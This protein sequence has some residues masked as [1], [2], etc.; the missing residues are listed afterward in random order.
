MLP[1]HLYIYKKLINKSNTKSLHLLQI[2]LM[3]QFLSPSFFTEV[4]SKCDRW[5]ILL[6]G[7]FLSQWN[8]KK[9]HNGRNYKCIHTVNLIC[10]FWWFQRNITCSQSFHTKMAYLNECYLSVAFHGLV[11]IVSVI[12]QKLLHSNTTPLNLKRYDYNICPLVTYC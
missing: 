9:V 3:E 12:I 7:L 10:A 2:F 6:Y 11:Y 1:N 4:S 8:F 5:Y